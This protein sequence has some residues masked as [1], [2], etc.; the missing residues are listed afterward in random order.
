MA[1]EVRPMVMCGPSGS[2]K[3][4]L[5]QKLMAEYPDSFA[6][7]V[8]HTTRKP[9]PGEK[10]GVHYHYT[11]MDTMKKDVDDKKFIEHATFGGNM[12]GTSKAAINAVLSEGKV[13]ILDIETQGVRQVKQSGEYKPH[14]I[15]IK[16]PSIDSLR[17]RLENRKTET[18]ESLK[19]RL[20]HAQAEIDYGVAKGN[21]DVIIVN[22]QLDKAYADLKQYVVANVL[23]NP[24]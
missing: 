12:Y 11:D 2:G 6:F 16:P 4:T 9:R 18:P 10:D 23:P 24:K 8:S 7:C 1:N 17:E 19:L 21:F 14:F 22:D 13:A 20:D 15:F 5:L 3:S